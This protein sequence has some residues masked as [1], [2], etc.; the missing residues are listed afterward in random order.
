MFKINT[1]L[2][3]LLIVFSNI[4]AQESKY[5]S[6]TDIEIDN[7]GKQIFVAGKTANEVRSY[8]LPDFS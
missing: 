6:P 5:F 2:T 4:N 8:N 3:I 7:T 1:I